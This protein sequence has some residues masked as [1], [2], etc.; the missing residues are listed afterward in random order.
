MFISLDS[1][2]DWQGSRLCFQNEHMNVRYSLWQMYVFSYFLATDPFTYPI[3]SGH[4]FEGDNKTNP[5]TKPMTPLS[6]VSMLLPKIV[7]SCNFKQESVR[8]RVCFWD[9]EKQRSYLG[10]GRLEL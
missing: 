8:Q 2:V 7:A 3:S 10:F 6:F 4:P 1:R 9:N 5:L